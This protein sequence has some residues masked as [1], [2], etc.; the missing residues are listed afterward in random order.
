MSPVTVNL[1]SIVSL[2]VKELL[3]WSRSHIWSLNDSS[4]IQ[5]H[6]LL[7]R[8]WALNH[9]ASLIIAVT[10][11]AVYFDSFGIRYITLGVL[12]KI[13]DISITHRIFRIQDNES[14]MCGFYCIT[15][16]EYMFAGKTLLDHFLIYFVQITIKRMTK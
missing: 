5:T 8:K 3:A 15:F 10:Y 6:N 9:L 16:R 2:N 12:K 4:G 1:H 7:V 13:K 14:I 11:T